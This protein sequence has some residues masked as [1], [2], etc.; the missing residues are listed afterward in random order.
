[1]AGQWEIVY[2]KDEF[3]WYPISN[4]IDIGE[5]YQYM[6]EN[7][8]LT[9]IN[10]ITCVDDRV[11]D[12]EMLTLDRINAWKAFA[13]NNYGIGDLKIRMRVMK[14]HHKATLAPN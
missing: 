6:V 9:R 14:R 12:W 5:V 8:K 4:L 3:L 10:V 11:K 7:Y 1:M 13:K 2:P